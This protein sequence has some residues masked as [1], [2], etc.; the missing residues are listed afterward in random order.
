MRTEE[1][2]KVRIEELKEQKEQYIHHQYK[3]DMINA[4][5]GEL[6]YILNKIKK[7]EVNDAR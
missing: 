3:K 1:I 2:I 4:K 5:I 6:R 7:S